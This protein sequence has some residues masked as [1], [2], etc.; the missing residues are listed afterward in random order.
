MN[1]HDAFSRR[2]ARRDAYYTGTD[3]SAAFH[4]GTCFLAALPPAASPVPWRERDADAA[5][6]ETDMRWAVARFAA[7]PRTPTATTRNSTTTVTATNQG[8]RRGSPRQPA[9]RAALRAAAENRQTLV[10][11]ARGSPRKAA[12][13]V[14]PATRKGDPQ[15]PLRAEAENPR[16]LESPARRSPRQ[17]AEKVSPT[18]RAGDPQPPSES[19]GRRAA[20]GASSQQCGGERRKE[21][22]EERRSLDSCDL[23]K[24]P[25]V[26]AARGWSPQASC[27]GKEREKKGKLNDNLLKEQGILE[28]AS[29][30]KGRSPVVGSSARAKEREK[31]ELTENL[32]KEFFEGA[33]SGVGGVGIGGECS[34]K[35]RP[36]IVGSSA[37]AHSRKT[38]GSLAELRQLEMT[39]HGPQL[40]QHGRQLTEHDGR[41]QQHK[42]RAKRGNSGPLRVSPSAHAQRR[43]NRSMGDDAVNFD[44]APVSLP[45][46]RLGNAAAASHGIDGDAARASDEEGDRTRTGNRIASRASSVLPSA[47]N[48]ANKCR[49]VSPPKQPRPAASHPRSEHSL[50]G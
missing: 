49:S 27:G 43:R 40:A 47:D 17:V 2:A 14:S 11:T 13:K 4:S 19:A 28:G 50:A 42:E 9:E 29:F 15:P 31:R 18:A 48:Q 20:R 45:K 39:E 36:P 10:S 22:A 25:A 35:G 41:R 7:S 32:L 1:G 16:T 44:A 30:G 26:V 46:S 37:R 8:A 24:R 12:E 34:G 33:P 3:I 21:R 6:A 23:L 38:I 5:A